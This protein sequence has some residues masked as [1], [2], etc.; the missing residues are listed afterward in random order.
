VCISA[1]RIIVVESVRQQ[2]EKLIIEKAKRYVKGDPMDKTTTLGP[3]A[4]EDLRK[5]LHEQVQRSIAAGAKCVMGGTLPEG[6][7]FYYPATVLSNVKPGTPAF[8]EELFGPVVCIV[9]AKDETEALQLAN[10][11]IYGL[12]AAVFTQDKAKGEHIAA[13]VLQAGT[14]AVN[15]FIAS[16]P[17]LPFGGIKQSGY[18]RELSVEGMREFMN[19]KTVVVR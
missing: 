19:I 10:D 18:G 8:T 16:D 5:Q 4:R 13:N 9:P 1:K 3:M 14:C 6:T 7:G 12:G 15:T 2:F 17:R 11:T